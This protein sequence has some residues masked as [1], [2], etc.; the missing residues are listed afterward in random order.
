[1]PSQEYEGAREAHNTAY[2]AYQERAALWRSGQLSQVEF[3]RA[4]EAKKAA[5]AAFDA[6][7]AAE[8]DRPEEFLI[9]P[10]ENP[11]RELF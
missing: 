4:L 8:Q 9:E 11:Q 3:G 7:F 10:Q 5:D 2:E 1:M 6:A